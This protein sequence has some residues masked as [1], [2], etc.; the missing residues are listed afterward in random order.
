MANGSSVIWWR[1]LHPCNKRC[2]LS[3][4]VVDTRPILLYLDRLEHQEGQKCFFARGKDLFRGKLNPLSAKSIIECCIMP[5]LMYGSELWIL[6]STLHNKLESFQ[7]ELAKRILRLHSSSSNHGC[8]IALH[9]PSMRAR[10]LCSKFSFLIKVTQGDDSLSYE[11]FR[12]L[13]ASEV[14]S[15][16]LVHQ[17][18]FLE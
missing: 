17:C 15:I 8:R 18:R 16:Q 12:S 13:A 5:I 2:P 1:Y 11:V 7:A 3:W 9:W 6:N 14:E 10:V 4:H